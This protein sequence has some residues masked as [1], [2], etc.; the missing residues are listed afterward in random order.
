[1]VKFMKYLKDAET[2]SSAVKE[3][4]LLLPKR[5]VWFPAPIWRLTTVHTYMQAKHSIDKPDIMA[6]VF[7]PRT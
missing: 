4:L 3:P 2:E 1:M 5:K 6:Q 7:N